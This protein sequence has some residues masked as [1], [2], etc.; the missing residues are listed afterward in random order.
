M[1]TEQIID[2]VDKPMAAV[3]ARPLSKTLF[4]TTLAL[5]SNLSQSG[6]IAN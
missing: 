6:V 2:Q 5:R 3:V 4:C 1:T